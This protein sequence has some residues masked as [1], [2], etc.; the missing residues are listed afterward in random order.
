MLGLETDDI[1]H[2]TS[3]PPATAGGGTPAAHEPTPVTESSAAPAT[4]A[5]REGQAD[6][7]ARAAT[8]TPAAAA[9]VAASDAGA[10]DEL[11]RG[12]VASDANSDAALAAAGGE[13]ACGPV[14]AYPDEF[15][16]TG[17]GAG[18]LLCNLHARA[19]AWRRGHAC[20]ADTCI[21]AC[22]CLLQV[23]RCCRAASTSHMTGPSAPFIT[24]KSARAGGRGK[25][26]SKRS[27]QMSTSPPAVR[28]EKRATWHTAG[29]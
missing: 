13:V 14:N 22:F 20:K 12:D 26:R 7:C 2:S 11:A 4:T 28:E 10:D 18:A 5:A 16:M 3:P 17:T 6:D 1:G 19:H 8:P 23:S 25:S 27:A 9:A 24:P 15:M 29:A 21:L